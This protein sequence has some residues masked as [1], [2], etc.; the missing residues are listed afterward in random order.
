MRIVLLINCDN[1]RMLRILP[2]EILEVAAIVGQQHTV[3]T[4]G[5]AKVFPVWITGDT[6]FDPTSCPAARSFAVSSLEYV[7]SSR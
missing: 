4:A 7:Q 3:I 5:I 2:V 6:S 1:A